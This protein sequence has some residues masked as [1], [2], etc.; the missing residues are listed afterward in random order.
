MKVLGSVIVSA[1]NSSRRPRSGI[2]ALF[3][4]EDLG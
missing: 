3:A 1:E 4:T 2:P